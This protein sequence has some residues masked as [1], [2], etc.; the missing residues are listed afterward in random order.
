[1]GRSSHWLAR[2]IVPS[3]LALAALWTPGLGCKGGAAQDP[4]GGAPRA[5]DV[6]T[7]TVTSGTVDVAPAPSRPPALEGVFTL[8][9]LRYV[10][11]VSGGALADDKLPMIV[12][13]HGMGLRP[14]M[15]AALLAS[16]PLRAR[17]ILPYGYL[18][19]GQGFAWFRA[20]TATLAPPAQLD[21]AL[22]GA[23]D[24]VASALTAIRAA[25][26]TVGKLVVG[27]FSQGAEL[28]YGLALLHPEMF[29]RACVMSGAL[30]SELLQRP[31]V[32]GPKPEVHGFHGADDPIIRASAGQ[33]TIAG[34]SA[35]GY[36]ADMKVYSS[37]AHNFL[38]AGDDVSACLQ[39][40]ARAA[41]TAP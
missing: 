29:V 11:V 24:Q 39:A 27:G 41:L 14:R 12:L 4:S 16:F 35:L 32:D 1:M 2:G 31:R 19:A 38:A 26:P 33:L 18:P 5:V 15:F 28:S 40:G 10:E 36:V 13:L 7:T 30:T 17:F 22:P 3:C 6:A 25:R 20:R 8:G 37:V 9:G 34:F 23:A 21:A